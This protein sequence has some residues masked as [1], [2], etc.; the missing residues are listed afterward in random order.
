MTLNCERTVQL[1]I[2]RR[3]SNNSA[4]NN[5]YHVTVIQA[6]Q[7]RG[8]LIIYNI[9]LFKTLTNKTT[10][11]YSHQPTRYQQLNKDRPIPKHEVYCTVF[12][13]KASKINQ[14]QSPVNKW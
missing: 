7:K 10:E 6:R 4:E 5:N 8:V 14:T 2:F 1:E 3:F 11:L 13:H 12:R 9:K